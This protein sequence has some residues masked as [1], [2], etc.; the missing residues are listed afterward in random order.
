[1]LGET[2]L[3]LKLLQLCNG[4]E[5]VIKSQ[6]APGLSLIA[7]GKPRENVTPKKAVFKP[8]MTEGRLNSLER[9]KILDSL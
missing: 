7:P 2:L 9:K 3:P 5:T 8:F 1:M 4:G 6:G